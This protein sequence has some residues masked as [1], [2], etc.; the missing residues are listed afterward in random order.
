MYTFQSPDQELI[1]T[2]HEYLYNHGEED[3]LRTIDASA[4][5]FFEIIVIGTNDHSRYRNN[6]IPGNNGLSSNLS[7]RRPIR[8]GSSEGF[9]VNLD[10]RG[11]FGCT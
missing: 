2:T 8:I 6:P 3:I 11:N 1:V 4:A 9:D 10:K 7:E 5:T